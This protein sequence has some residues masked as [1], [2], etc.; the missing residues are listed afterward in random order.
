M[1]RPLE[2]SDLSRL[3]PILENEARVRM[4]Y[5]DRLN[6]KFFCDLWTQIIQGGSSL[7]FIAERESQPR[8]EGF[9]LGLTGPD[10][11]SG[12]LLGLEQF[13]FV[14]GTG[15]ASSLRAMKLLDS[16]LNAA[17]LKKCVRVFVGH[18]LEGPDLSRMYKR[19]G[20]RPLETH[21]VKDLE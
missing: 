17:Y 9:L 20:F 1:I 8:I 19:L 11:Y 13:W 6:E 5:P 10:L 14:R 4:Q 16:F 12:K 21:F 2:I 7:S 18:W 3:C 15:V